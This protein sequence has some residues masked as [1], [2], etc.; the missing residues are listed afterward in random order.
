MNR[1]I[2]IFAL[3]FGLIGVFSCETM[4]DPEMETTSTFPLNGEYWVTYSQGGSVVVGYQELII[5]NT[6][7]D[8]GQHILITE[9]VVLVDDAG[10]EIPAKANVNMDNLT[11]SLDNFTFDLTDTTTQTVSIENGKF[12]EES[13]TT[14]AG[15]KTDSIY[16]DMIIHDSG[17]T[18]AVSGYKYTGWPAD[19]H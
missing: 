18:L 4:D 8:D 12:M 13:Y 1:K 5:T 6:A 7:A 3:I 17:D 10:H 15:N 19:D 14:A 16:M 2:L 9:P 11:F